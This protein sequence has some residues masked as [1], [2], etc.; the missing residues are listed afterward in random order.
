MVFVRHGHREKLGADNGLSP[1]GFTQVEDLLRN[2]KKGRLPESK[3]FWS[4]PKKRCVETLEPLAKLAGATLKV[5]K[6]LD[7]QGAGE[8]T[9]QFNKR[10]MELLK[11]AT[12]TGEPVYLCSHGDLIP[13]AIDFLSGKV[14][15]ISKGQAIQLTNSEGHWDLL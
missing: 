12:E 7:E 15:D 13:E 14:V 6:L 5:E 3:N 10:I 2:F 8:S 1:K 4:S 11:K 9:L